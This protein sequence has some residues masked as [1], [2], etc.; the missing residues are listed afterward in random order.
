MGKFMLNPCTATE[1]EFVCALSKGETDFVRGCN[2]RQRLD[3]SSNSTIPPS[4]QPDFA[5]LT[6]VTDW[7]VDA[8][9]PIGPVAF[10]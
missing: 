10:T 7:L 5:S 8:T 1:A 4:Q 2:T 9:R 3:T 6:E